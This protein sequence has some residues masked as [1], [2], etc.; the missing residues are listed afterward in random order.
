MA[1]ELL[2]AMEAPKDLIIVG[3]PHPSSLPFVLPAGVWECGL[4]SQAT[5]GLG[6]ALGYWLLFTSA[7][8][9]LYEKR[10]KN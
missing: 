7:C 4:D 8:K 10:K 2:E 6:K 5:A 3:C 9:Y 1:A